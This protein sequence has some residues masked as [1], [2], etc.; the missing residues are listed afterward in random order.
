[1]TTPVVSTSILLLLFFVHFCACGTT[2]ETTFFFDVT[3]YYAGNCTSNDIAYIWYIGNGDSCGVGM[4]LSGLRLFFLLSYFVQD[5]FFSSFSPSVVLT[6]FSCAA[7]ASCTTGS[8]GN[9]TLHFQSTYC[10]SNPSLTVQPGWITFLEWGSS[11]CSGYS[12]L[13]FI[14]LYPSDGSKCHDFSTDAFASF[15]NM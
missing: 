14:Y 9:G 2:G 7:T 8:S 12:S 4:H 10:V 6:S 15:F 13:D 11:G 1:M 5:H 3:S